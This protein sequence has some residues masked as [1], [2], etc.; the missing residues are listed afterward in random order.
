MV[1]VGG[2][3][4][5]V[6]VAVGV[7][8]T[9]GGGGRSACV[10]GTDVGAVV[11]VAGA[12]VGSA[13]VLDGTSGARIGGKLGGSARLVSDE[14]PVIISVIN[15]ATEPIVPNTGPGW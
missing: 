4:V 7:V 3:D 5:V 11:V 1:D 6:I 8:V 15:A 10:V 13:V 9:V 14:E 12:G 2:W